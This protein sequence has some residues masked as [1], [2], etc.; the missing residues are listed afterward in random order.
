LNVGPDSAPKDPS[1]NME[2]SYWGSGRPWTIFFLVLLVLSFIFVAT[3]VLNP[4]VA[5]WVPP[6]ATLARFALF[7]WF[8]R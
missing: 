7:K 3:G 8:D 2:K 5:L 1:G 6:G 4:R